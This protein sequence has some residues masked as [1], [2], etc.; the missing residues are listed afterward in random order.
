M[1]PIDIL[2]RWIIWLGGVLL[3]IGLGVWF[4]HAGLL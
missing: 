2:A 4:C 3:G 1:D